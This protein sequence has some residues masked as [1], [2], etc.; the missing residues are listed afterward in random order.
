V[1]DGQEPPVQDEN[2]THHDR[3]RLDRVLTTASIALDTALQATV[4]MHESPAAYAC[5]ALALTCRA[6]TEIE[7]PPTNGVSGAQRRLGE[8]NTDRAPG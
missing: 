5:E 3:H 4:F 8:P 7:W 2:P 6:A 1:S